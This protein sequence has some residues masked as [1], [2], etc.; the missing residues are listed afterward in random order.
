MNQPQIYKK[1]TN[2]GM[3]KFIIKK[4]ETLFYWIER[5]Y[6]IFNLYSIIVYW[7]RDNK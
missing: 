5:F 1:I 4:Y 2:D 7:I 3:I 6:D